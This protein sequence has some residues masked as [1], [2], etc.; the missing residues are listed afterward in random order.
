MKANLEKELLDKIIKKAKLVRLQAN[1][2]Y[3][4][5]A[6]RDVVPYTFYV[7]KQ[8]DDNDMY[9]VFESVV[10]S[11]HKVSDSLYMVYRYDVKKDA[12]VE[13][14]V[15]DLGKAFFRNIKKL[16]EDSN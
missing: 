15:A 7:G 10:F 14:D 3:K 4:G 2:K 8:A 1:M 11:N 16:Y 9:V 12:L 6:N 13:L 5:N